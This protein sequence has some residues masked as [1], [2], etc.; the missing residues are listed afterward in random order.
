MMI[1]IYKSV[2]ETIVY[3]TVAIM[4]RPNIVKVWH[5]YTSGACFNTNMSSNGDDWY[6]YLHNII[7]GERI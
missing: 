1:S 5:E 7:V 4:S 6:Q 3:K 2:F